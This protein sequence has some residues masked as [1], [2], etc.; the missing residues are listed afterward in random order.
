[1][2]LRRIS[3]AAVGMFAG[4]VML[5]ACTSAQAGFQVLGTSGWTAEWDSGLDPFVDIVVDHQTSNAVFIEKFVQFTQPFGP[6]GESPTI[7]IV[8]RQTTPTAVPFVVIEDEVVTNQTGRTWLDFHIELVDSGDAV[9]RPDLTLASGGPPPIGWSIAPFTTA[10]FGNGNTTLDI[11]G[12]PGIPSAPAP[13]S[14][15]FPGDGPADGEL[16]IQLNVHQTQPF[17]VWTLKERPT[18]PEPATLGLL[19]LGGM[20]LIRRRSN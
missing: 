18:I 15:W 12:G 20:F 2:G 17:T 19:S 5:A 4:A 1:M 6:N 8:F 16:W 14:T 3:R 9:Y 10:V 11:A 13:G 7:N